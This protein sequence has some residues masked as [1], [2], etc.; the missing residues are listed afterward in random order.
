M[1]DKTI[2]SQLNKKERKN[3]ITRSIISIIDN[4]TEDERKKDR[5][6]IT[7]ILEK[8]YDVLVALS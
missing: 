2:Y 4:M 3:Y 7:Q 6:L 5:E 8:R 1:I